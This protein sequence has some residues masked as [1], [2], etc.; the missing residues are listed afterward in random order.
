M[1]NLFKCAHDP[2]GIDHGALRIEKLVA[3]RGKKR[4]SATATPPGLIS[5]GGGFL[6]PVVPAD[7]P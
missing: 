6:I 5:L 3:K 7:H 4:P 2:N 1:R